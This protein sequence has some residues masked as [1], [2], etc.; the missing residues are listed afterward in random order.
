MPALY[1]SVVGVSDIELSNVYVAR[2]LRGF[3]RATRRSYAYGFVFNILL[4]YKS[5]LDYV[6]TFIFKRLCVIFTTSNMDTF[7][8]YYI[9]N[10]IAVLYNLTTCAQ[11]AHT[12]KYSSLI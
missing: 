3:T 1:M 8:Y 7:Y 5:N 10:Y 9:R 2:G 4:K 12:Y 6:V 11:M